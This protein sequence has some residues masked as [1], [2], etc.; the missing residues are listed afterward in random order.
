MKKVTNLK[1]INYDLFLD[2]LTITANIFK[3]NEDYTEIE[4]I[5]YLV[6]RMNQS[7]GINKSQKRKG[8]TL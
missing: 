6:E 1:C 8:N 4:K 7:S 3:T 2:S 5:L